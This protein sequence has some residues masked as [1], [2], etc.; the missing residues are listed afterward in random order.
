MLLA[1]AFR[2]RVSINL[3]LF[4]EVWPPPLD[5]RVLKG[6]T[7]FP[8][9]R[10]PSPLHAAILE[11][12]M[13]KLAYNWCTSLKEIALCSLPK[14]PNHPTTIDWKMNIT[15]SNHLLEK[16]GFLKIKFRN[17]DVMPSQPPQ[18]GLPILPGTQTHTTNLKKLGSRAWKNSRCSGWTHTLC[19]GAILG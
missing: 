17:Q 6:K 2:I 13:Q 5:L 11:N 14:P 10:N 9:S 1:S 16:K 12:L 8:T 18:A 3:L 19:G 7:K 4:A 15:K